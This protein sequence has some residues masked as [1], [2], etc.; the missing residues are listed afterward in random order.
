MVSRGRVGELEALELWN[1]EDA[2][3]LGRPAD[4]RKYAITVAS[5]DWTVET[6]VRQVAQ[7]N[8]NLDPAFQRRNAWKDSRRSRLIESFILGFPVPQVVLAENPRERGTFIVID[9]KQRLLTVAGLYLSNYRSYWNV[10]RLSGLDVL[11]SFNRVPLDEFLTSDKWSNE[12]RQLANS[13]I[14]TTIITGFQD[15]DVL[16][17]IF[18]RINT[19]SVPLS[20]QELR[21][22]LNRGGFAEFLLAVTTQANPLWQVLR[23]ASPDARLRDVELLLRL[24]SLAL[25]ASAYQGDMRRFLDQTMKSLNKNWSHRRHEIEDLTHELFAGV[26]AGLEIFGTELG[27][28]F[29]GKKPEYALNRALFE[30]QAYYLSLPAVRRLALQNRDALVTDSRMLFQDREFTSS[31]EST[32]KSISNYRLR[33]GRYQRMLQNTLGIPAEALKIASK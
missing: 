21:Q 6:I 22:V 13:D 10:E 12:Q 30:V 29:T 2:V 15:E 18:Y 16:Y 25:F 28:K 24:I 5:R 14:R 19:G 7:G 4:L 27:R 3:E 26:G 23:I 32:T 8:I 33:F 20:S 17:D 1:T 9:G 31:I 11:K